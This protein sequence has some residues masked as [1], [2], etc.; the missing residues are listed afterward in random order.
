MYDLDIDR[1]QMLRVFVRPPLQ[2]RL[3]I[4]IVVVARDEQVD[5]AHDLE[6]V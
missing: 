1:V 5:L 4:Q 2:K 3:L 6:D